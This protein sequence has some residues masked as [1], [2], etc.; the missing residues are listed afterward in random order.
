[1]A[2]TYEWYVMKTDDCGDIV[3]HNFCASFAE[4][5]AARRR[6]GGGT[7]IELVRDDAQGRSSAQLA[8]GCLSLVF[9]DAAGAITATVPKWFHNECRRYTPGET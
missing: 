7:V 9:R 2:A 1:M 6:M 8:E 5:I 3:E 4:A